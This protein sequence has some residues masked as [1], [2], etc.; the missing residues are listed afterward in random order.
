MSQRIINRQLDTKLGQ[1]TQEELNI[2]LTKI[3]SKKAASI[4]EI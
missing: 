4:D 3:K 1:Y 2:V